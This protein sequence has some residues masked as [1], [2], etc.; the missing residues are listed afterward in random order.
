M[1]RQLR[2]THNR[3]D[4]SIQRAVVVRRHDSVHRDLD[5]GER[6]IGGLG[7]EDR[8]RDTVRPDSSA[9]L[10]HR[11]EVLLRHP[12]RSESPMPATARAERVPDRPR[13]RDELLVRRF[14]D[15]IVVYDPRD[16]RTTLMNL[17]AGALLALCD[18]TRAADEIAE[19]L[20]DAFTEAKDT[21]TLRVSRALVEL[22][23]EQLFDPA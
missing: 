1:H 18:G 19:A 21:L 17:S 13:L 16:D 5:A 10:Q 14:D 4:T 23:R 9:G 20:G 22:A 15:E 7:A 11:L 8:R 12:P 6:R 2:W 3:R